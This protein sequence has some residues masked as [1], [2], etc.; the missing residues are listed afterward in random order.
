MNCNTCNTTKCIPKCFDTLTIGTISHTDADVYIFIKDTTI[1]RTF[2]YTGVSSSYG[3]VQ[4][5]V[6]EDTIE[7]SPTHNYELWVTLQTDQMSDNQAITVD[8]EE[9]TCLNIFVEQT[10]FDA[11]DVTL[12]LP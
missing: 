12:E 5:E 7:F 2:R 11:I 4:L 3:T 10:N 8:E 6:D 1:G 9:V